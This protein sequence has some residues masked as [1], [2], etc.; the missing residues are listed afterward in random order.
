MLRQSP[1][2]EA[3]M[4]FPEPRTSSLEPKPVGKT[5]AQLRWLLS[6]RLRPLNLTIA[7]NSGKLDLSSALKAFVRRLYSKPT[8]VLH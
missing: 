6:R 4:N 5:G 2:Q 1:A 7:L 3:G 8:K